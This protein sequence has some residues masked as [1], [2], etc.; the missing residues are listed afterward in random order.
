MIYSRVPTLN[1]QLLLAYTV[2]NISRI[3]DFDFV[4]LQY[5]SIIIMDKKVEKGKL[6]NYKNKYSKVFKRNFPKITTDLF[7]GKWSYHFFS[8]SQSPNHKNNQLFGKV[9]I[10]L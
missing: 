10:S 9:A 2:I 1:L 5:C 7:F 4:S 8:S 3:L 6:M